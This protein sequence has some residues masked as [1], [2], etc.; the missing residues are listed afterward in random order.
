MHDDVRRLRSL[1]P[2]VPADFETI[3]H[4]AIDREHNRRYQPAAALAENLQRFVE[5]RPIRAR[6]SKEPLTI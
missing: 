2:D 6:P 4:K 1:A 5:D 3:I